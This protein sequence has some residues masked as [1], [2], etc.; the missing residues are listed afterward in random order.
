MC[1]GGEHLAL[2]EFARRAAHL[3][4]QGGAPHFSFDTGGLLAPHGVAR[5]AAR[6]DPAGLADMVRDTGYRALALGEDDLSAPRDVMLGVLTR[7]RDRGVPVVASNLRCAP[8]ARAL[9]DVLVDASD[10]ISMHRLGDRRLAFI[11]MIAPEALGRLAPELAAGIRLSPLSDSVAAAVRAARDRGAEMIVV[12]IDDGW[13][14]AAA[15]RALLLAHRLPDDGRPDLLFSAGSGNELR[16][17]RPPSFRPAVLAA[18]PGHVLEAS[19]RWNGPRGTYDVLADDAPAFNAPASPIRDLV[20]RL[21]PVYCD[22]WGR[23]LAGARLDRP[24]DPTGLLELTAEVMR[25]RT[26]AEIALLNRGLLDAA[27]RPAHANG[28][29]ESDVY[30]AL[31]YDEPL[32]VATVPAAWLRAVAEHLSRGGLL[33]LGLTRDAD[34]NVFVN[35]RALDPRAT[36]RVVSIRFLAVG[37]DHAL[38][39]E[40]RW[41][42]VPD[43][44]LR[45]VVI[46]HLERPRQRDPRD[47]LPNVLD[48]PIWRV[49]VDADLT[50]SGT[51]IHN[52]ADYDDSQFGVDETVS[53]GVDNRLR[54]DAVARLWGWDNAA[55]VAYRTTNTAD[56]G[57]EEG[58]DQ[59]TLRS[60]VRWR[61]LAAAHEGFYVP[62]PYLETYLETEL[63]VPDERDF[64]H[65]L[66]RPTL[67]L[68]FTLTEH[69]SLKLSGGFETELLADDR[70]VLPGFGAQL[71][72][73]PWRLLE[74]GERFVELAFSTDYF[75]SG[76]GDQNRQ[77][78]RGALSSTFVLTS[79]LSLGLS[80]DLFGVKEGGSDLS[81]ASSTSVFLRATWQRRWARR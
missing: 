72:L 17:A 76:L 27:W 65:L 50:F 62:E 25:A 22:R 40:V 4:M 19:V 14:S 71:V 7:L 74:T 55:I 51:V 57:F 10:G 31:Q 58:L 2:A 33:A 18:R 61:G 79:L 9:C 12:S 42:A 47:A 80:F 78:L 20:Q 23:E 5:F 13:G 59:T 28:L 3:R 8:A 77:T 67:G 26:R 41:T 73:K 54:A 6:Q 30:V 53:F 44:T 81:L 43:A 68:Q 45:S 60:A 29:T 69:L 24:M 64:R 16:F 49:G 52:P 70:E 46:D 21:G 38:P 56:A 36:Y 11:A 75:V 34:G 1:A 48:Q 66:L 32:E 39:D 37:G 35:G 63:T 15:S